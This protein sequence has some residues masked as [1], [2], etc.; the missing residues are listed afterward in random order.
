MNII[1]ERIKSRKYVIAGA[2]VLAIA[3]SIAVVFTTAKAYAQEDY[4]DVK[5]GTKTVAVLN[6][7]SSAKKVVKNVKNYYLQQGAKVKAIT[8]D[9][10]MKV[11]KKTYKASKK[12]K[13]SSVNSAVNYIV[14][15]TKKRVTYTVKSGDS[16]WAIADKYNLTVNEIVEMNEEKDFSSLYPGDKLKLYKMKPMVTVTATQTVTSEEKIKYKTVTKESSEVLKNTTIVEQKG[17]YGKKKVTALVTSKNGKVV[18]TEVQE[19]KIIRSPK[20]KI[21]IKGTGTLSA[22]TDGKTYE[23]DGQA[24]AQY[25]LKFVGHPYVYGGVSLTDGADCSGFVLSVYKYFGITMAHDAGVMRSYGR[26][27]SLAEAQPGD[28]ICYY[29]HVGIYIGGGQLVHAVNENM[30]I[31]VTSTSYIG[32]VM[33]VRRIVE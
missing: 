24:V 3:L 26:E 14:S 20:N 30:G 18:K 23:G 9:P 21:I 7:E 17:S 10:A 2:L 15:G 11:V 19:S 4:W 29:G 16:L 13:T 28:L 25:A 27:V 1:V 33:T 32:P 12:P 5:I 22:P 31:A 8:C 6:S